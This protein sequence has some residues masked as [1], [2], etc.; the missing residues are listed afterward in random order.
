VKVISSRWNFVMKK[1]VPVGWLAGVAVAFGALLFDPQAP[2]DPVFLLS[3]LPICLVGAW[4]LRKINWA[5]ADRVADNGDHLLVRRGA[6]ELRVPF[7]E[8]LNIGFAA[9]M[10]PAR[11]SV[12]LRK[13]GA[14]GDEIFFIPTQTW[15][16]NPL[17]RNPVLEAL[18][19][20]VDAARRATS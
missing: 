10:Q 6:T 9:G 19:L 20:K 14:L 16:W 4:F 18:I 17:A 13:S 12:R 1:V 15:R 5:L 7:A 2:S 3:L 8:I 11:L